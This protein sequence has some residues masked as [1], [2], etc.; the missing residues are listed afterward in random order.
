M[1]NELDSGIKLTMG[2]KYIVKS[3]MSKAQCLETEGIFKGYS[4]IASDDGMCIELSEK[5]GDLAGKIRVIPT[6]MLVSIDIV[7][8]KKE[9]KNRKSE[10]SAAY[11]VG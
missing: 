3:L 2:S 4:V 1:T 5:H 11:Y 10:E 7:E 6:H 9:K 8:P